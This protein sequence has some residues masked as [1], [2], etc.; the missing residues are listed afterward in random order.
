[1]MPIAKHYDW[2]KFSASLRALQTSVI[3]IT[4]NANYTLEAARACEVIH[5]ADEDEL[6]REAERL[7]QAA[8][9]LREAATFAKPKAVPFL[10]AAE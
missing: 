5:T 7:E 3:T 1:M 2:G 8:A 4:S 9:T 6:L 10:Q